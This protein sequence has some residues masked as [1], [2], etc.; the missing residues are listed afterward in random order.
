MTRKAPEP[1]V[2][3]YRGLH[4]CDQCGGPLAPGE[5]GGICRKCRDALPRPRRQPT[6]RKPP[7]RPPETNSP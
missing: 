3:V 4:R 2:L 1:P 6:R 5:I 7:G